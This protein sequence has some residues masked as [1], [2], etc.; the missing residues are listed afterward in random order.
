[1]TIAQY[2]ISGIKISLHTNAV[3]NT[4]E[5]EPII[6]SSGILTFISFYIYE[7]LFVWKIDNLLMFEEAFDIVI[8]P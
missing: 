4:P 8:K 3:N 2:D 7:K 5:I 1:M 6:F